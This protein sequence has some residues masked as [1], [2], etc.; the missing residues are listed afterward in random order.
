MSDILEVSVDKD[1]IALVSLSRP[2]FRN[3]LSSR[4][5]GELTEELVRTELRTD[6]RAL[7]LT[8]SGSA[9]CAGGDLADIGRDAG[10]VE[11][12]LNH[13]SYL[14]LADK[15]R[16]L[17]KPLVVAVN[18]PAVGAGAALAISGDFVLMAE[19]SFLCFPFVSLGLVPDFLSVGELSRRA[20]VTV[21]RDL[22]FSGRR[23]PAAEAV[24]LHLADAV[25]SG[26]G[27]LEA[28]HG[29]AVRL[30][31][32]G[33]AAFTLA[34]DMIRN[35]FIYEGIARDIEPLAVSVA[36]T[37]E[38]SRRTLERFRKKD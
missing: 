25:V 27:I 13:R 4:L 30:S 28:A 10:A 14:E 38:E 21:T 2:E 22:I 20:G 31:H 35:S 34:K 37:S 12:A 15:L 36:M 16:R 32:L 17:A 29:E 9:F 6:V 26:A 24:S 19:E 18:G 3:A 1:G 5:I 8:G 7:V 11:L 23:V 33:S